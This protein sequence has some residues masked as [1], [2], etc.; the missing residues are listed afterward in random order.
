MLKEPFDAN[1][2]ST[3]AFE[4]VVDWLAF[5]ST[6]VCVRLEIGLL[7]SVVLST[8]PSPTIDLAMPLTVPAKVGPAKGAFAPKAVLRQT[9]DR[10]ASVCCVIDITEPDH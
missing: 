1:A 4:Y 7:A 2:V 3:S 10:L 8:L 5:A 9:R 6:T